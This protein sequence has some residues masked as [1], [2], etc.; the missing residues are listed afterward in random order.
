MKDILGTNLKIKNYREKE[1][2]RERGT[3]RFQE[4]LAEEKEAEKEIN[5]FQLELP[6]EEEPLDDNPTHIQE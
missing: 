3:K 5:E 4:R 2:L 1:S 6:L